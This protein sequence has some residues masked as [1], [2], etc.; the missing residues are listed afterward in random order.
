MTGAVSPASRATST[1]CASNGRPEGAG[2]ACGLTLRGATP[3]A[4]KRP[5]DAAAVSK[6]NARRVRFM[7]SEG[8]KSSARRSSFEIRPDFLCALRQTRLAAKAFTAKEAKKTLKVP[9]APL[10]VIIRDLQES[11]A[12]LYDAG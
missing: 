9:K 7:R 2:L 10:Q 4:S 5:A 3:C 11:F 8:V 6:T 1:K 12:G